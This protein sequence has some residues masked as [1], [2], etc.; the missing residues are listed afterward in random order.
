MEAF[1][2]LGEYING[3]KTKSKKVIFL[4]EFPWIDTHKSNFVQKFGHFWNSYCTRRDDLI[5][6]ICGSAASFM[7]T[8]V[9]N[10]QKGLHNR[11][12]IPI[13]LLPFNLYETEEFLKS[14]KVKLDRYSYLQLYMAIGGI[15]HYL[16]KI[17]PGDTA[18]MAIDR[19]CFET[20]GILVNEYNNLFASLF[21]DSDN[22]AKIVE[23]LATS[24]KGITRDKLILKTKINSGGTLTKTISELSESG[25]ISEYK[26]YNNAA[27]KTLF[28]LTDEYSLFY[29]KYIKNNSDRS[30]KTF[31]TS[32]SYS[33]WSGFA[34]ENLCLKH[35]HQILKGLSISGID[36]QSSSWRNNKV[37]IDL[38]IDRSDRAINI[39]EMK[40]SE[41]EFTISKSY[42][43][44]IQNKKQEFIKNMPKRKN[45][46]ITFVT[47]F[48]VKQNVHSNQIM[49]NQVTMDSLFEKG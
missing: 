20:N 7:V 39:C 5:V 36:T 17:Q 33:S 12:S 4:D 22:H 16:E 48:G 31:Y 3:L 38:L 27:K 32:R 30:W 42:A 41:G 6:V 25:F 49:D 15:P 46:F 26:P 19:L 40:F 43:N 37:Q 35:V 9:I 13:R 47:T 28:R 34:F 24:Q 14:K 29:L 44:N 18:P 45:V 1:D 23:I 2:L 8:K 21:E 10:D 11:I